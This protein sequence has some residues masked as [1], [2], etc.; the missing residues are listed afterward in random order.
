MLTVHNICKA[1]TDGKICVNPA[2]LHVR[3]NTDELTWFRMW[4]FDAFRTFGAFRSL[5]K[6]I[7]V[8]TTTERVHRSL[9]ETVCLL[10][11]FV[12]S[13][14]RVLIMKAVLAYIIGNKYEARLLKIIKSW[15]QTCRPTEYYYLILA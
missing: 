14:D 5:V 2:I 13:F 15:L 6:P 3:I 11:R 12:Y 10:L 9:H 4:L 1:S 8:R 7:S